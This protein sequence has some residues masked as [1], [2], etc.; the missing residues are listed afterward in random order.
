[1]IVRHRK[2]STVERVDDAAPFRGAKSE[3]YEG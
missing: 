1:M 3:F 2:P